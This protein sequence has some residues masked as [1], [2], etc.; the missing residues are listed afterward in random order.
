MSRKSLDEKIDGCLPFLV[1]SGLIAAP[2]PCREFVGRLITALGDRLKL[3]SDILA[4]DEYFT[5][6]ESL[7]YDEK[8]FD[9]RIRS[10]PGAPDLLRQY[11]EILKSAE[12]FSAAHLEA[13]FKAWLESTGITYGDIIH[14]LRLAVSGKTTGPG[15]FE[16]LELLGKE[17]CLNRIDR[18]LARLNA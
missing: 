13:D 3:F 10:A 16:C 2:E 8:A 9:K 4:Y 15:M 5:A 12:P 11:R 7:K 1:K 17:R 14:A 6:D 18:T